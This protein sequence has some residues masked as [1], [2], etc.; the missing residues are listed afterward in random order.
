MIDHGTYRPISGGTKNGV[1]PFR[2]D[3]WR[4]GY[5]SPS[6]ALD[7]YVVQAGEY[8]CKA[9]YVSGDYELTSHYQFFYHVGGQAVFECRQVSLELNRGDFLMIPADEIYD[10]K[11]RDG[12]KY[13]WFALE[14]RWPET[15]CPDHWQVLHLGYDFVLESILTT[16]RENLILR[17][18]AYPLRALGQFYE[19]MARVVELSGKQAAPASDY[20]DAVRNAMVFLREHYDTPF[21][22]AE[23]AA[24]VGVSQSHL[25]ALF[26]RWLGESPQRYHMRCRVDQA[27]RLLR[28]QRLLVFEVAYHVGFND[29]RY[30]ARVFKKMTGQTP[31]EYA[32]T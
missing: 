5:G 7:F 6:P 13:H 28:G 20:P 25:R 4:T 14:G 19:T 3:Y 17:E 32:Q 16:M 11:S 21:S 18:T 27:K 31:S 15:L 24:A 10:Y 23:T 22:A 9:G 29:A 8:H 2:Y 30:F 12:V 26:S 1:R